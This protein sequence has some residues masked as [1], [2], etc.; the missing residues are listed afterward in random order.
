MLETG[1]CI[2]GHMRTFNL[3]VIQRGFRNVL[4]PLFPNYV[5][6]GILFTENHVS[7]P[8]KGNFQKFCTRNIG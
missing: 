8:R 3:P 7:S 6:H 1:I 5:L 2:T 4:L